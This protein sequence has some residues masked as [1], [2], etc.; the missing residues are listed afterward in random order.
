MV[1]ILFELGMLLVVCSLTLS[2]VNRILKKDKL[3][4]DLMDHI[5]RSEDFYIE[6]GEVANKFY[7][8]ALNDIKYWIN[9]KK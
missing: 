3:I 7:N 9:K 5:E 1:P 2:G 8:A 6:D 4:S